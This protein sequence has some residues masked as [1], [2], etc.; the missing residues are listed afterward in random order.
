METAALA[1]TRPQ[2]KRWLI[3]TN[4]WLEQKE[5]FETALTREQFRTWV[6]LRW[7]Q[8]YALCYPDR[9]PDAA[10][11][12][13]TYQRWDLTQEGPLEVERI[14][15]AIASP[16]ATTMEGR[17]WETSGLASVSLTFGHRNDA[18]FVYLAVEANR[19]I[20]A[21]IFTPS[22]SFLCG[23]CEYADH[24]RKWRGS[25]NTNRKHDDHPHHPV[26]A[27]AAVAA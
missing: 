8:R 11:D 6:R 9:P 23:D 19:G 21:G 3:T 15:Q 1:A 12:F 26:A 14:K 24:C 27:P 25:A 17:W 13:L 22:P 2:K 20:E 10:D 18:W 7:D 5:R 16:A 4:P